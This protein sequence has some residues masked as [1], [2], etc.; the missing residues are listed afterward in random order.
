MRRA[1]VKL[2]QPDVFK[3]SRAVLVCAEVSRRLVRK[4]G[5]AAA[6]EP[7][8]SL[9]QVPTYVFPRTPDMTVKQ[10]PCQ[11]KGTALCT[12]KLS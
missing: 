3:K 8:C 6:V 5:E 4:N 10:A 7:G 11:N 9:A 12:I 2:P 1:C